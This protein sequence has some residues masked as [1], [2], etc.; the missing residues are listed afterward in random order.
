MNPEIKDQA[1]V[2]EFVWRR[3]G[4]ECPWYAI[5]V[6]VLFAFMVVGLIVLF[7]QDR[8]LLVAA[9]GFGAVGIISFVYLPL[10]FFLVGILSW[11]VILVPVVSVALFYVGMMYIRDM[12]SVHPLWAIFL[13]MI[14]C[15]VYLIL[16][17][18]FLLPG[19]QHKELHKY[20]S[21]V[22]VLFDVSGSMY[23]IDDLPELPEPGKKAVKQPTRQDKILNWMMAQSAEKGAGDAT[24]HANIV[25][26]TPMTMY[27]YGP[28]VDEI[29]VIQL[30][31]DKG[32]NELAREELKKWLNPDKSHV[33]KPTDE[34]L[35]DLNKEAKDEKLAYYSKRLDLVETLKS[36]T[37]I[38]GSSL[39][40]H[41]LENN[42]LV[43]AIIIV[44]DGQSNLGSD[45]AR[46]EFLA[47]VNNPKRTIPVITIGVGEFRLPVSI[48]IDDIQAPE[49]TRPDDKFPIRVPVVSSGIP[50]EKFKV[51]LE[52]SRVKNIEGDKVENETWTL[53]PK[54]GIF[55]GA[56]DL[57]QDIVEF[58]IDVEKLQ[59]IRAQ[60]D[61]AGKLLGEWQFKAR[62]PRHPK[63]AGFTEKEHVTE[64]IKV[65]VQ[66]RPLR[67][68]LFAGGA[69][70]EYQFL[71]SALYREMVE[72]RMDMCIYL[73]TGKEDHVDQDVESKRMLGD[74]PTKL[75]P[76]PTPGNEYMSLS[77]YDVIVAFDPDWSKLT[78]QQQKNLKEWVSTR[79][80]G[81]IFVAG[82]VFSFQLAR[83]KAYNVEALLSLYPVVPRDSRLHGSSLPS[84]TVGHN[85]S[86]PYALHFSPA[87]S[88][89]DFIK[90][91]ESGEGPTAGWNKFFWNDEKT[92]IGPGMD[93]LPRRGFFNYYPVERLK[94]DSQVIAAF[95]GPK[96]SR[97][98]DKSIAFKDQQPFMVAMRAGSG[99]SL[100]VGSGEL[101]RLR[102]FKDGF[103]ERLWIKMA[104][105]VAAGATQQKKFGRIIMSRN[106][107]VGL[108]N[109]EAQVKGEDGRP[110]PMDTP[111]TVYV[112]RVDKDRDE[113]AE[114]LSFKL[115]P[116]P[117]DEDSTWQGNFIGSIHIKD[118]G[119]YEFKLPIPKLTEKD[120]LKQN[121][122][123]RKLN[124]E[125]DNV[126]TNFAYL[127]QMASETST[128]KK[129]LSAEVIR[130]IEKHVNVP[131][132]LPLGLSERAGKRL[133][134]Q[135]NNAAAVEKCLVAVQPKSETV[136]GKLVDLWD[137][138][139]ETINVIALVVL[140]PVVIGLFG[141]IVLLSLRWWISAALFFVL[142]M[143]T[144]VATLLAALF[145][146]PVNS[147][148][149]VELQLAVNAIWASVIA[150][151][152]VGLIGGVI[153][154]ILRQWIASALFFVLCVG[155]S[156]VALAC[157]LLIGKVNEF[158]NVELSVGFSAVLMVMVTLLGIEWL[159]RK[160]LRLA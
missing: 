124:P 53:E 82:P 5:G 114:P 56:G 27:R 90:L 138:G 96:E 77:D 10:A 81:V 14:R 135:V 75:D 52:V 154:L 33:V 46:N 39:Q 34:E 84:G 20:E 63:E 110:L 31:A 99:K 15:A 13:G 119:E 136:K 140:A 6:P 88:K 87:A 57:Q 4:E 37:N 153:L 68:L 8:K 103:H 23:T 159:A 45:D 145:V 137:R 134:F 147:A 51:T 125:T 7:I 12:R 50:G 144:S 80:G 79:A 30:Q 92:Q 146:E 115:Q 17:V 107:P 62:V 104:R 19:C 3:L 40:A 78:Q 2:V 105:Y 21:K 38:G 118:A 42:S 126:R 129:T 143:I 67:V 47:R 48:R 141:G 32:K 25:S 94:P 55:K 60:D 130:E 101:W 18:V 70:R 128:L 142:C 111:P 112:R 157:M 72:K 149:N 66:K 109:F 98:G 71:R 49:E 156:I 76:D 65:Q 43:Q 108:V 127:Y 11:L 28:I 9:I 73:Q 132:D 35:Q 83:P 133:F 74:F 148:L 151:L 102:S 121:V 97:F 158:M 131:A 91:D 64:P 44:S 93:T 69:T 61:K 120:W 95:A 116:K 160:L 36:G 150:P 54:E 152:V 26:R 58:D 155:M 59:K 100:Y 16:A 22:I 123:V 24:F 113:K 86:R 29:D 139:F 89:F 1:E 106:L 122:V 117:F 85:A 41:K